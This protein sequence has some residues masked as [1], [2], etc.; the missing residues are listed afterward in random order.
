[1]TAAEALGRPLQ[2]L[3]RS[4][5]R[6]VRILTLIGA[7]ALAATT[8]LGLWMTLDMVQD[9]M[10]RIS[11]EACSGFDR[12]FLDIQSDLRATSDGLADRADLG[13]ALAGLQTRNQAVLDLTFRSAS[14]AI[15]GQRHGLSR[16][17]PV[18]PAAAAWVPGPLAFGQVAT[19]PVHFEGPRPYLEMATPVTDAISLPAGL[20]VA[21]VDLTALWNVAMD[22]Q[23][24][25]SGDACLVEETG[26]L[27][28]FRN[29]GLLATGSTLQR[30]VGW[31]PQAM[32]AAPICLC[33]GLTGRW[34]LASAR[35]LA[36]VPWFAVLEQPL[37]E[38]L[39]PFFLACA[40]LFTLLGIVFLV[41]LDTI[42]FTRGR[43]VAPLLGLRDSVGAMAD[44]DLAQ[45]FELDSEDE[46][47]QL[48][49]S[50]HRMGNQ[51]QQ[52][53]AGQA[54]QILAL[55]ESEER[56]NT[57]FAFAPVAMGITTLAEGRFL[58]VN[59]AFERLFGYTSAE[60]QLGVNRTL[61]W[62][63]PAAMA[64]AMN[65]LRATASIQGLET[66]VLTKG[67]GER[68]VAYSGQVVTLDGQTCL[69]SGAVD[70]TDR[71]RAE[72]DKAKLEA[73]LAQAQ[74]ME[75]L[76]SLAGGV[77]HDMNNVLGA[78]LALASA[79]LQR[80]AQG[81]A[82]YADFNTICQAALRGG[83]MV[84]GLLSFA[85]ANP[86]EERELDLNQIL[87]DGAELLR[88]TT[89]ARV[90]L[91]L[92][93]AGD[94]APIRGD[95]H[96]LANAFMNLCVN[97][98][99]AMAEQ[100]TLTLRSRNLDGQG[101]EVVVEDDGCGMSREILD[102]ALDPFFTTKEVG[103]GTG[104]GL[105]MVYSTVKANHGELELHSEPGR[106]TRVLLRFPSC[107]AGGL[108]P[109]PLAAGNPAAAGQSRRVLLV[110][111][112]ELIRASMDTLLQV[113]GHTATV[114]A[115]GEEAIRLLEAGDP[116]E[117]VILDMN[118]P[119]LGGAGTL[120]RLRALRPELPVLLATGRADQI[121]LDLVAAHP[122]TALLAKPYSLDQLQ[123]MLARAELW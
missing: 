34:V 118:M 98:V 111:D 42:R 70:C 93:L 82:A 116:V 68:W 59:Q 66:R 47:G 87:R 79:N 50:I 21:R 10:D 121:A 49:G 97:A 52:A 114:A 73:Q 94:L 55:R 19:S 44:G 24:G 23:V 6:R 58:A 80:H 110:D 53:F 17:G 76:G 113:L 29:P 16:P 112:D 3:T 1:M 54:Q 72:A 100:G 85:R 78:I 64:F 77:A 9:R 57:A 89:L 18:A 37:A 12:F 83:T 36:T 25:R 4:L 81:S 39:L 26:Q 60:L 63:D 43:I 38:A 13:Q 75:S 14:G 45:R 74:K 117:L 51:L 84:K 101:V 62:A 8:A 115:C 56:F 107:A 122:H 5:T 2:S 71:K 32:V 90:R 40:V 105:A 88:H 35:P 20:L 46:L 69:L 7:L 92:D 104:L 15:R 61:L 30:Q 102:R 123:A 86:R 27:V 119:G 65:N 96:A 28:A 41:H 48:A 103:K 120:P 11:A 67:G 91:V 33:R 109:E 108:A 31:T 22:L 106:G 95:G 99:D